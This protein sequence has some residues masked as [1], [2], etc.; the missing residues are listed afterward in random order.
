MPTRKSLTVFFPAHNEEENIGPLVRKTHETLNGKVE[1][2]EILAIN[3]GSTDG[4]RMVLD[5]LEKEIPEFRGVHHEINQGYG[6]AVQTGFRSATKDLVF[7]SD[8]DGQFDITEISLFLDAID[9]YEAVL[10]FRKD[11]QDPFHRKVFAKCWGTLIRI[12]FGI[13]VRDLDCAFKMFRRE[14]IESIQFETQGAMITTELLAKLSKRPDFTFTQIGVTHL[15][16]TAG[17][18]SGGSPK[19]VLRAF[20]ELFRMYGRLKSYQPPNV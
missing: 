11:R 14:H 17:E 4:T 12:L 9:D 7:F 3:D 5:E 18:Q 10:G 6:G 16:R 20:K 19:V 8:G 2:F 13:R 15:P 1:D